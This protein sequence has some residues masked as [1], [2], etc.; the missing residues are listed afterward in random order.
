MTIRPPGRTRALALLLLMALAA[1][2]STER[3]LEAANTLR[4]DGKPKAALAAYQA[5]L[6]EMGDG[7]LP[8]G[9]ARLRAKALQFAAEI[10][11][12]ELGDYAG[13]IAYYRRIVS[14]Q[15]A[16]QEAFDA[17]GAIGDI[18]RER[19]NDPLAAIAQYA[20]VAARD[21]PVAPTFQLKVIRAWAELKNFQQA[22]MEAG[23]LRERWPTSPEADEAQL[24][25]AQ[26]WAME[27]KAE[28]A[29][30]AFRALIERR[31]KQELVAR[32]LEGQALLYAQQG[33]FDRA[34]ELY[35]QAL[36]IHPNIEAIQTAMEGVTRRRDASKTSRPGDRNQAF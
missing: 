15:P 33:R 30:G 1:C 6:A 8:E 4:H 11:Y 22:R 23:A 7:P 25:T 28:E 14:L 29:L 3:R 9:S 17:R 24:L 27:G 16:T 19:F 36:P 35:A 34:L 26:A 2:G 31:P 20:D 18:Y 12:L 10:S 5:L 21:A 13:A 32:A